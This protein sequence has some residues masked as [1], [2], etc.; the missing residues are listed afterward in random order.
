MAAL[1][2]VA[3][4]ELDFAK[5]VPSHTIDPVK[6]TLVAAKWTGVRI[7]HEPMSFAISAKW[8]FTCL[9]LDGVLQNVVA[10]STD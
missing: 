3:A 10:N 4:S 2:S 7:L 1:I 6:L 5:Q 9:A 8:L